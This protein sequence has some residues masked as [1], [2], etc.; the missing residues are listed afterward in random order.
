MKKNSIFF[1][2]LFASTGVWA[3][4]TLTIE[5]KAE[6]AMASEITAALTG[7]AE[8]IEKL[9]I[10]GTANVTFD[11]CRA[12]RA[13]FTTAALK[14]L[15]LSQAKFE[16]D[17]LPGIPAAQTPS[18]V[19]A[20]NAT[21]P[22]KEGSS[23]G[24]DSNANGLLVEEVI[25]PSD[26]RVVSNRIFRNFKRLIKITL[27]STVK[28]IDEGAFN[29]CEQLKTI[30]FPN[31]LTTIGA[32]AFYQC[33]RLGQDPQNP[34]DVLPESVVGVLGG[35]AFRQ[36]SAFIGWLPEGITEIGASC[37]D[38]TGGGSAVIV[39]GSDES[40]SPGSQGVTIYQ[41]C[42]KIG[43]NAFKGQTYIDNVEINRVTPPEIGQ[44]AFGDPTN[45]EFL[46]GI[47]LYVP[48]GTFDAYNAIVPYN[49]MNIVAELPVP[50]ESV[51][52]SVESVDFSVYPNPVVN[53]ISV[54]TQNVVKS[55]KI[56]DL[57]GSVLKNFTV[58][59]VMT[60]DVSDLPNGM[61]FIQLDNTAAKFI[62]K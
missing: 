21:V 4:K 46:G 10:T 33:Y 5:H 28:V 17:S 39:P 31:G 7:N 18:N 8:E 14:T 42:A 35:S 48:Q 41:H 23:E 37:F 34:V 45:E 16:N 54:M 38:C 9:V 1:A 19:G 58:D 22:Y 36:T 57:N 50:G 11:D 43:D 62:K 29:K 60:F 12:I 53:T 44:N 15:D 20:F 40:V 3:Q 47:M 26:L 55:V 25:L 52:E 61:Y 51:V 27:P 49:K 24:L 32:Y 13:V 30:N 6:N 2:V 56:L 59:A